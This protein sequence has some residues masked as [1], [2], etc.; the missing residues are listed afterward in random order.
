[1]VAVVLR[2]RL[3]MSIRPG[4]TGVHALAQCLH[5]PWHELVAEDLQAL[6]LQWPRLRRVGVQCPPRR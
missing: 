6:P 4:L 3:A 2:D 5:W 1:V